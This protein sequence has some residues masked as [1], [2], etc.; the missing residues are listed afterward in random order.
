M[1]STGTV[2]EGPVVVQSGS[3]K[4]ALALY[5]SSDCSGPATIYVHATLFVAE[6][7]ASY[8]NSDG[9]DPKSVFFCSPSQPTNSNTIV[10]IL[11][12]GKLL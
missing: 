5:K 8:K 1:K 9:F 7:I 11:C 10:R 2:R 6:H 12:C 3:K 4:D